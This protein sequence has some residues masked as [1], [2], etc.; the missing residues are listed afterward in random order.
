MLDLITK[1]ISKAEIDAIAVCNSCRMVLNSYED[2]D[3][4]Q[5]IEKVIEE[6]IQH[7]HESSESTI[8][9]TDNFSCPNEVPMTPK[10]IVTIKEDLSAI[11]LQ[12]TASSVGIP[13]YQVLDEHKIH[14]T[15]KNYSLSGKTKDTPKSKK[16]STKAQK[17]S[18]SLFVLYQGSYI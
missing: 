16:S 11:K 2:K 18:I 7:D 9:E 8:I 14:S 17:K 13:T 12:S 10:D 4:V 1:K 5:N 15:G 6:A 3:L